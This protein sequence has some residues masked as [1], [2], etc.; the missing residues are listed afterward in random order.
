MMTLLFGLPGHPRKPE[1]FLRFFS[2][3][4]HPFSVLIANF[5]M[6]EADD[7]KMLA[8]LFNLIFSVNSGLPRRYCVRS[9]DRLFWTGFKR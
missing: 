6:V 7:M 2:A 4:K 1:E 5:Q 3:P 8:L 9:P